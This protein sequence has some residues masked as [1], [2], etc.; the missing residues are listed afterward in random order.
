[1][2]TFE[3]TVDS[4]SGDLAGVRDMVSALERARNLAAELIFDINVVL[5]EL[6]SNIIKYGFMD[7]A[8]HEIFV[9][10]SAT[11][12]AIEIV[13]EDDGA[14]FDPFSSPEPD[15]SRPLADRPVGGLGIHFVRKLMDDVRYKR[16]NNRNYL[17]IKKKLIFCD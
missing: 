5:D 1:M 9:R 14:E 3:T 16:E 7:E 11:D 2:V 4:K 13:I 8:T 10:L 6:I 12:V 15:L 17:F